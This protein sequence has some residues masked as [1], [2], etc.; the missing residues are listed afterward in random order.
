MRKLRQLIGFFRR[1]TDPLVK[2]IEE[3][4]WHRIIEGGILVRISQRGSNCSASVLGDHAIAVMADSEGDLDL[5]RDSL[6]EKTGCAG[7][8]KD[9][10]ASGITLYFVFRPIPF[11]ANIA[12]TE[13]YNEMIC[14]MAAAGMHGIFK[15]VEARSLR[16]TS[17]QE[18]LD[19]ISRSKPSDNGSS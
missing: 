3:R 11:P 2:Q 5:A 7:S 12:L 16:L 18:V 19:Q 17:R 1:K 14:N 6:K 8:V 13:R 10:S 15:A 4:S 9:I